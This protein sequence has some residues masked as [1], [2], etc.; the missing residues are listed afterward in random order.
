PAELIRDD[1]ITFLPDYMI[2]NRVTVLNALPFTAN[3]KV[4]LKA[5]EALAETKQHQSDQPFVAPRTKTEER[6]S[7]IWMKKMKRDTVSVHDNFFESGGNSLVAVGVINTINRQLGCSLPLQVLFE[8]PTIEQ[9][10]FKVDG[11]RARRSSR[12]VPLQA[13]G[14]GNPVY[15]WPGLG[16][17]PMNLRRLAERTGADQPFYGVQAQG[18]NEH[19]TP[20]ATI[21][22]MAE[23][24][25]KM[26]KHRQPVGPYTLWG[27][28]FGARI[29][30]EAAYQLEQSGEQVENLLLIA[31]GSP[32]VRGGGDPVHGTEPTFANKAY[33]TILFSVFA[34]N[35][36]GPILDECLKV[37]KDEESFAS[38]IRRNFPDL[39]TGVVKRVIGIVGLTYQF[40]YTFRELA[41]RRINAPITIF[42]ARGDDYSFIENSVGYFATSPTTV[43]LRADHYS[44]L[45]EPDVG[46]LTKKIRHHVRPETH[47]ETQM[48]HVNIKHFPASLSE[49]QQAE[50]VTNVT[51]AIKN[52]FGCDE[53]VVSIALE[54]VEKESWNER[55]Y[56]PEIVG[57]KELLR[58]T[59][60]Y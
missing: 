36:T 60:N 16:G 9:L 28:S 22:K 17:Y 47:K 1:L 52:A 15:C 27:Y 43:D 50:L 58:K 42:K 4:D 40:E 57:R 13:R 48:P 33:V 21:R 26:I 54:P 49:E 29:A 5:L 6:I 20:F 24:D 39:D 44:M 12:L 53:G 23:E 38:F 3:G 32:R 30:F 41:E 25:V 18:I 51:E 31:P 37:A 45:K 19:E 11:E 14:A 56:V 35:I 55:V 2:P 7:V 59:P 8:S 46:E 10:A 34:G